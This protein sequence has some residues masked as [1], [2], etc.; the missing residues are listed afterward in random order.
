MKIITIQQ[1]WAEM[2]AKGIKCYEARSSET[3]YRGLIAI[4]ASKESRMKLGECVEL[5]KKIRD[6]GADPGESLKFR[7]GCIVAIAELKSI[8][9]IGKSFSGSQLEKLVGNWTYGRF[10]W[11]LENVVALPNPIPFR[12]KQGL[13]ELPADVEAM[14]REAICFTP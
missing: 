13:M 1:P 11:K 9:E 14:C 8:Y 6:L 12:G 2:V 10:A 7:Y 4:H 5:Y 3:E